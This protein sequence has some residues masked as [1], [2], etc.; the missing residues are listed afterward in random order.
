MLKALKYL[1]WFG[2]MAGLGV[3]LGC[4][5]HGWRVGQTT[6]MS[7]VAFVR[8]L[9]HGERIVGAIETTV[10]SY[11][12]R[13]HLENFMKKH[14]GKIKIDPNVLKQHEDLYRGGSSGPR[15]E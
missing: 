3:I 2:V 15:S 4:F 7:G 6:L 10:F 8:E 12:E 14:E 5:I 1:V 13:K 11:Q 9:P